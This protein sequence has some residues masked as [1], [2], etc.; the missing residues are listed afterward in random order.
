MFKNKLSK[1]FAYLIFDFL[2]YSLLFLALGI[3][4]VPPCYSHSNC[5]SGESHELA[6]ESPH[7]S[8]GYLKSAKFNKYIIHQGLFYK[9]KLST[10]N[11]YSSELQ[12]CPTYT[13]ASYTLLKRT[14]LNSD[15]NILTSKF[16]LYNENFSSIFSFN[17]DHP[18]KILFL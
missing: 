1:Y 4:V 3:F 18:P 15:Y 5:F 16:K 11:K 2:C 17:I 13:L 7:K 14:N 6:H 8:H 9:E 10:I 12:L